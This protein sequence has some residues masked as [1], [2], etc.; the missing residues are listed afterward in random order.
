MR[1]LIHEWNMNFKY[2]VTWILCVGISGFACIFLFDSATEIGTIFSFGGA[3][4]AAMMGAMMLSKEE[5]NHTI[6]F[7]GVLPISREYI[8][9]WKYITLIL[10]LFIFSV[11]CLL[12]DMVAFLLMDGGVLWK[13][14][15]L[16]HLTVFV[17]QIE[18]GTIGYFI[19]A[20]SARKQVVLSIIVAVFLYLIDVMGRWMPA[21]SLAKYLTPFYITKTPD[22]VLML[23]AIGLTMFFAVG[24]GIIYS[25]R[26]FAA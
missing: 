5:E 2:L 19:S 20:I 15:F 21:F 11:I 18:I 9:I 17:M 4:F 23:L 7:L 3:V 16:F 8:V 1:L 14:L 22:M 25:K 6:D 10:L 12:V 24:A 13:E 26:D